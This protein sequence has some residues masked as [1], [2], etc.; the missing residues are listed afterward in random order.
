MN[1]VN[2]DE[3]LKAIDSDYAGKSE[4][5]VIDLIIDTNSFNKIEK[6]LALAENA[7]DDLLDLDDE[8]VRVEKDYNNRID[9]LQSKIDEANRE[10]IAQA[11]NYKSY[12]R[13]LDNELY[14]FVSDHMSFRIS[15]IDE[16]IE[17]INHKEEI[18]EGN[19]S[20]RKIAER[21]QLQE[22]KDEL[23]KKSTDF[24]D[25]Q[26]EAKYIALEKEKEVE[27][28]KNERDSLITELADKKVEVNNNKK[29]VQNILKAYSD[30]IK[31]IGRRI[32]ARK[33]EADKK[34]DE[35]VEEYQRRMENALQTK[36]HK[37]YELASE[38]SAIYVEANKTK[39]EYAEKAYKIFT[40]LGV[41]PESLGI[42]I[43]NEEN[44]VKEEQISEPV[45]EDVPVVNNTIVEEKTDEENQEDI[46]NEI[47]LD[48]EN[49][50][51]YVEDNNLVGENLFN[52]EENL[53]NI[54]SDE[55]SLE[56]KVE[57]NNKKVEELNKYIEENSSNMS[58]DEI[59][60]YDRL[61]H[62]IM[63]TNGE[64]KAEKVDN[65]SLIRTS[66][67]EY[68]CT[69]LL[70]EYNSVIDELNVF[71]NEKSLQNNEV[72]DSKNNEFNLSD[73]E[74]LIK[75]PQPSEF[76]DIIDNNQSNDNEKP[77]DNYIDTVEDETLDSKKIDED[78]QQ[79]DEY[80]IYGFNLHGINLPKVEES[81]NEIVNEV[82]PFVLS[83]NLNDVM[84]EVDEVFDQNNDDEIDDD[85]LEFLP[86]IQTAKL[87]DDF[88]DDMD[89]NITA[90]SDIKDDDDDY[91][92]DEEIEENNIT[93]ISEDNKILDGNFLVPEESQQVAIEEPSK[94]DEPQVI[95]VTEPQPSEDD[96][97]S[98][99][100]DDDPEISADVFL[101][102]N[103]QSKVKTKTKGK[104][105]LA[106]IRE[107][108]EEGVSNPV[109]RAVIEG[110][111]DE[112]AQG[113]YNN[114]LDERAKRK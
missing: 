111:F 112:E 59:Q 102:D 18:L 103:S 92:E 94:E 79:N 21:K 14:P 75:E 105:L 7:E 90:P 93:N 15:K 82:N 80:D 4:E 8:E 57:N 41:N 29:D 44:S 22:E 47:S 65:D 28:A 52:K 99:K 78:I 19:L 45:K 66:R 23:L 85:G 81:T 1:E 36:D 9:E 84:P 91:I 96:S 2:F 55:P 20:S 25:S 76:S 56:E 63:Y 60:C 74:P 83:E 101:E 54:Q 12:G 62:I 27:N 69:E 113:V 104:G 30:L 109:T 34:Y 64:I 6:I 71:E 108:K 26:I 40:I 53:I 37:D 51:N 61:I 13:I 5:E 98:D 3:I 43:K 42:N 95:P 17:E 11:I 68:I 70:D 16:R 114:M 110:M 10:R 88:I 31:E 35:V 49:I 97:I 46:D 87:D 77:Q 58:N 33:A 48:E 107:K 100:T 72:S 67:D 24:K 38:Y 89:D 106:R 39:E 32:I 86:P 50:N 73:D